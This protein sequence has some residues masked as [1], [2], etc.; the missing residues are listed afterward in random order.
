MA[1]NHR[2]PMMA[3][4]EALT[5][6]MG[7]RPDDR[8]LASVPFS[9]SYGLSSLVVP[10][11]VRGTQ[12]VVVDTPG[13]FTSLEAILATGATVF[14]TVPAFLSGLLRMAEAP[15][16][17]GTLRLLISA[18]AKLLPETAVR[19]RERY[20][21]PVHVF[22]GASECGGITYDAEGSAAER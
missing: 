14:P 3:D 8:L 12:L 19:F 16:D 7:I 21:R 4:D 13:S 20:G 1:A 18:G 10:A 5:R 2:G 6:T 15:T 11:I 22:Y 17:L 9:H